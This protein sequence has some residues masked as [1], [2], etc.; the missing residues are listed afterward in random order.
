MK[1][2]RKTYIAAGVALAIALVAALVAYAATREDVRRWMCMKGAEALS[3]RLGTRVYMDSVGISVVRREVTVFGFGVEDRRRR[4]MLS[5]DTVSARVRLLPLLRSKVSIHGVR[6][7]GIEA[8][9]YRERPDTAANCQFLID[10]F[11]K[12][13]GAGGGGEERKGGLTVDVDLRDAV[14]DGMRL[15]WDVLSEPERQGDTLDANHVRID[16][17][18]LTIA[19]M[20]KADGGMSLALRDIGCRESRSG[21]GLSIGAVAYHTAQGHGVTVGLDSL[22]CAYRDWVLGI[23]R[24]TVGQRRGSFSPMEPMALRI[25]SMTFRRDNGRPHK[26]MGKPH[27]GYYDGGHLDVL[28]SAEAEVR[29]LQDNGLKVD[30]ARLSACDRASGLGIRELTASLEKRRDTVALSNVNLRLQD[31]RIAVGR[32][33]M[34]PDRVAAGGARVLRFEPF[35]LT[36]RVHLRDIARPFAPVLSDFT[37]PLDLALTVSGTPDR[38]LFSGIRVAT[39]D[40]RLRLS[41]DGDMIDVTKHRNL[42]L[43][44]NNIRLDA[45]NGIKEEIV[46]HF[47]KKVRLKMLRQMRSIGDI[48]YHGSMGIRFR[49]EDFSG[50]LFTRHGNASFSF[51]IDGDT[52]LMTGNIATDSLAIGSIMNVKGLDRMRANATY[53]FNV[54][55]RRRGGDSRGRLP[56]GWMKAEVESVRFRKMAF[57]DIAAFIHSDGATA[58]GEMQVPGKLFDIFLKVWYTQTD[59]V[60]E[61]KFKPRLVRHKDTSNP[62]AL[63]KKWEEYMKEARERKRR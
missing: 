20:E 13:G 54:A 2:I 3:A 51:A 19:G 1:D 40:K 17:V 27:R 26:R 37:T 32:M 28:L 21:I 63:F 52:K 50:T 10:A 58:V 49:H 62:F 59:S 57:S 41:A 39:A 15:R 36:A 18:S 45:R 25:D 23:G 35:P 12:K 8:Q 33:E 44:F 46:S 11:A 42:R 47:S 48:R 34:H 22:R 6:L 38:I 5:A 16:S 53:S 29:L 4:M 14:L 24:V 56:I 55:S 9:L 30:V 61:M 31:T 60:Q 7:H 43:H